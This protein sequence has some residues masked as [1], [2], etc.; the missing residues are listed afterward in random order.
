MKNVLFNK[1]QSG[2]ALL[3]SAA[4]LFSCSQIETFQS[5]DL[6]VDE[7][8]LSM[9]DL[10]ALDDAA[11]GYGYDPFS[12]S[13]TVYGMSVDCLDEETYC[14]SSD[15]YF[16]KSDDKA[17]QGQGFGG[18]RV[19]Y[20]QTHEGKMKFIFQAYDSNNKK[21]EIIK[22]YKI[23]DGNKVDVDPQDDEVEFEIDL[24]PE[25][26]ACQTFTETIII[27][28]DPGNN[29]LL[30]FNTSYV[31]LALCADDDDD[32]DDDDD[33]EECDKEDFYYEAI[34][35]DEHKYKFTYIPA[36]EALTNAV[37]KFTSPHISGFASMDGKTI[38]TVNRNA[39]SPRGNP[40]V[41]VWTG[42]I[43]EDGITF[44]IDFDPDCT[45]TNS[46]KANVW[47]DFKVNEVSKKFQHSNIVAFDCGSK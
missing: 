29:T 19:E 41:L 25:W 33:E 43:P 5:D 24:D 42:D 3:L 13:R 9:F 15:N 12:N 11:Y 1:L 26:E 10:T 44:E 40:T 37:V 21:S 6:S 20:Y 14:V 46:G 22:G 2:F 38:T 32:D 45:Q 27:Y 30:T 47:T 16:Y 4:L 36:C 31:L 8:A 17:I 35:E 34:D 39:K 23:G 18:V 28:T 7:D